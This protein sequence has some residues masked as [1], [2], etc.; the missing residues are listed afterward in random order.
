MAGDFN[1]HLPYFC[2]TPN[3]QGRE[4]FATAST[5]PATLNVR[6]EFRDTVDSILHDSADSYAQLRLSYTQ[7]R[8]FRLNQQDPGDV[9]HDPFEELYDEIYE[10]LYDEF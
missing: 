9:G 1:A 5:I 2:S 10:E 8:K 4:L 7:S 6:Y 3:Q